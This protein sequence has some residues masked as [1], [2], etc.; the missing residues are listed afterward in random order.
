MR[1][2]KPFDK[3]DALKRLRALDI[4]ECVMDFSGGNDE[5]GVD[6][7]AIT[8]TD[9]SKTTNPE[10]I[11]YTYVEREYNKET[12]L[13]VDTTVLSPQNLAANELAGIL[14]APVHD[15]FGSFAGDFFVSGTLT[16][17]TVEG[18]VEMTG[19]E[20]VPTE[21]DFTESF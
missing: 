13:W 2:N 15:R 20:E 1:E 6:S 7:T 17:N 12:K 16:Y 4:T 14:E 19:S 3:D 9:G 11:R 18:T 21:T 8:K 5:G 10:C